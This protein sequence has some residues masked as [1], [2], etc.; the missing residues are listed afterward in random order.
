MRQTVCIL[1]DLN[2][3]D[4][5]IEVIMIYSKCEKCR[6][7]WADTTTN[8]SMALKYFDD[9][10]I[11]FFKNSFYS[12][13]ISNKNHQSNNEIDSKIIWIM[14]NYPAYHLSLEL[15]GVRSALVAFAYWQELSP[16][17]YSEIILILLVNFPF[18]QFSVCCHLVLIFFPLSTDLFHTKLEATWI[19]HRIN[20]N[21]SILDGHWFS[22]NLVP[23]VCWSRQ[24]IIFIGA[25]ALV[26]NFWTIQIMSQ[27][28]TPA[29]QPTY[30]KVFIQRDYSDGT[31]VKFQT[32]FP[33]ELEGRVNIRTPF[34]P[35]VLSLWKLHLVVLL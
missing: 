4:F 7:L 20:T 18:N 23:I 17:L 34:W 25:V 31:S 24:A 2:E 5:S 30:M 8:A 16:V 19:F 1:L 11:D 13:A 29:L 9:I 3:F 15:C 35:C 28:S 26:N 33:P 32:R 12:F 14:N 10:L 21:Q 6:H 22:F 27:P